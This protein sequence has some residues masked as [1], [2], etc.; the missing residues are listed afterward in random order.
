M[1]SKEWKTMHG[2]KES[3]V[4]DGEEEESLLLSEVWDVLPLKSSSIEDI[5][6]EISLFWF[7]YNQC[8]A[9]FGMTFVDFCEGIVAEGNVHLNV[10]YDYFLKADDEWKPKNDLLNEQPHI[11]KMEHVEDMA[12]DRDQLL[13]VKKKDKKRFDRFHS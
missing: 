7:Q 12:L 6:S 8:N 9:F 1:A 13:E 2:I 11:L 5:L 10:E 4:L 3:G